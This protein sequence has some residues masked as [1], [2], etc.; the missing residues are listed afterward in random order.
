MTPV[1]EREAEAIVHQVAADAGLGSISQ[2]C[3]FKTGVANHVYLVNQQFVIR[4]GTADDGP[5]FPKAVA[6]LKV[7]EGQVKAPTLTYADLSRLHVPFNV[8]VYPFIPGVPL[9]NL[10]AALSTAEK[11]NFVL[12]IGRELQSLH[13][14]P[15]KKVNH[16]QGQENWANRFTAELRHLLE[17]AHNR[18][19][20]K[21]SR[22]SVLQR[23]VETSIESVFQAAPPVLVHNDCSWS[24]VIVHKGEL[25]A[26][27]DFDD[28]EIGPP[29][30]DY[31]VL[32]K[33]LVGKGEL[34]RIAMTWLDDSSAGIT[35]L[36]GFRE[37]CLLRQVYEILW[38]ATTRYSW[39][40]SSQNLATAEELYRDTFERR[41]FGEWFTEIKPDCP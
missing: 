35:K 32:F 17:L 30:E 25:A 33:M 20:L 29:E 36:E 28:A 26:L 15:Y 31:W 38:R 5:S 9:G 13:R 39:E 14:I 2:L 11:Y 18:K 37:R 27:V 21:P 8:M 40:S 19:T 7:I 41:L 3:R 4:I 12:G 10:W 34:P 23:T 1:T 24:N 22:L 16:F 6:V